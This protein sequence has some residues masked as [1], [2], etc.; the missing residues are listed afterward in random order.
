M[1]RFYYTKNWA[2]VCYIWHGTVTYVD[3]KRFC[4]SFPFHFKL[5][6]TVL[7]LMPF[8]MPFQFTFNQSGFVFHFM[9]SFFNDVSNKWTPFFTFLTNFFYGVPFQFVSIHFVLILTQTDVSLRFSFFQF[10]LIFSWNSNMLFYSVL[11][12][13]NLYIFLLKLFIRIF[14]F[15]FLLKLFLWC[16]NSANFHSLFIPFRLYK[17][18]CYSIPLQWLKLFPL[19]HFRSLPAATCCESHLSWQVLWWM[20]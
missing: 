12:S 2:N 6:Y 8:L 4:R 20:L 11:Y 13:L 19:F 15:L 10:V 7:Y 16:S 9:N 17:Y 14:V 3:W 1:L 5:V 18:T